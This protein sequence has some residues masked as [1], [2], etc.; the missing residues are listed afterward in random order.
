MLTDQLSF[1]MHLQV[2]SHHI[3]FQIHAEQINFVQLRLLLQQ[4]C[5]QEFFGMSFIFLLQDLNWGFFLTQKK[6]T[7][8]WGV[9]HEIIHTVCSHTHKRVNLQIQY[10]FVVMFW[11]KIIMWICVVF[12]QHYI[13]IFCICYLSYYLFHFLNLTGN[14]NTWSTTKTWFQSSPLW[15]TNINV[16]M[17]IPAMNS[18][19]I[20]KIWRLTCRWKGWIL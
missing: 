2:S 6:F 12:A 5:L 11:M 9:L 13:T 17:R 1:G 15:S 18:V 10:M 20:L 14:V 3:C 19:E 4:Q 16:S 8:L 7:N